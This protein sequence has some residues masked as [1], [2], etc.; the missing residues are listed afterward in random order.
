MCQNYDH[1]LSFKIN[2]MIESQAITDG[3]VLVKFCE[4]LNELI[5]FEISPTS[6]IDEKKSHVNKSQSF[7]SNCVLFLVKKESISCPGSEKAAIRDTL[8]KNMIISKMWHIT[9]LYVKLIKYSFHI[10]HK[11]E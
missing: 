7:I 11:F 1:D 4:N 10:F 8:K 2:Q 5:E 6:N 3:I 9:I